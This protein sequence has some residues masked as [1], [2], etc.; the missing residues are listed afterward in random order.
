MSTKKIVGLAVAW[1]IASVATAWFT[2][3]VMAFGSAWDPE[4]AEQVFGMNSP[5]EDKRLYAEMQNDYHELDAPDSVEIDDSIVIG[6]GDGEISRHSD[7]YRQIIGEAYGRSLLDPSY[8]LTLYGK[9]H[10]LGAR[11]MNVEDYQGRKGYVY[12]TVAIAKLRQKMLGQQAE[13]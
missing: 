2:A 11:G 6:D 9:V 4:E 10:G 5:D 8:T 7:D 13:A 3:R 1:G 12:D